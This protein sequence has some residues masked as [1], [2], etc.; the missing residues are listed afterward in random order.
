MPIRIVYL[1]NCLVAQWGIHQETRLNKYQFCLNI[2]SLDDT[3][4]LDKTPFRHFLMIDLAKLNSGASESWIWVMVGHTTVLDRK[5][6]LVQRS[7]N[8]PLFK[9]WSITKMV[10]GG[11]GSRHEWATDGYFVA[12]KIKS[13]IRQ[14]TLED[15]H[16]YK[17]SRKT[18]KKYA[19]I[20]KKVNWW[21]EIVRTEFLVFELQRSFKYRSLS[22]F[23][24][25]CP[26]ICPFYPSWPI[27]AQ[28][29]KPWSCFEYDIW[30]KI[31]LIVYF[32]N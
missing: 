1:P 30:Y 28:S 26:N 4:S 31:S 6:T 23:G 32:L 2:C 17:T 21:Q 12:P 3:D 10:T 5:S 25:F 7:R 13:F 9:K 11:L 15:S 22:I 27:Q 8:N 19:V 18:V 14:Y 24:H 16:Y 20:R 29:V